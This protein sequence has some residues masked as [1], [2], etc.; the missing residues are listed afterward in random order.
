MWMAVPQKTS[1]FWTLTSSLITAH[2][3]GGQEELI[4]PLTDIQHS[5]IRPN[6]FSAV[7][8]AMKGL[9]RLKKEAHQEVLTLGRNLKLGIG[10]EKLEEETYE[11]IQHNWLQM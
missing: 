6:T 8:L 5:F 9:D 4:M 10:R 7:Y 3:P 11:Y 1:Y 2:S